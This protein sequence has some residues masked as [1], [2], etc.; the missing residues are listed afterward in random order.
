MALEF[1]LPRAV[2]VIEED[3]LLQCFNQID[4]DASGLVEYSEF[5]E[6]CLEKLKFNL[7]DTE[8][9]RLFSLID[10]DQSGCVSFDEVKKKLVLHRQY[11]NSLFL[12]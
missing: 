9:T 4:T 11:W 1:K 8:L 7:S 3:E 12:P 2:T 5:R 6:L 10:A